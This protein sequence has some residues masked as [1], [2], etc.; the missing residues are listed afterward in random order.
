V[1]FVIGNSHTLTTSLF[2]PTNSITSTLANEF[3]EAS[4]TLY[5]SALIELGLYLFIITAIVVFLSAWLL[6]HI[7]RRN[8]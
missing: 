5:A 8:Q 6:R 1:S 2:T 3:T 7:H 4:N